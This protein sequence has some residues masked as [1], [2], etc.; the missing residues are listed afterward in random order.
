MLVTMIVVLSEA[1]LEVADFSPREGKVFVAIHSNDE[2]VSMQK[3]WAIQLQH[4]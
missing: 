3:S 4:A 2:G 1:A